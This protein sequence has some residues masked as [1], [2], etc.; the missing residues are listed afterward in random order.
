MFD[1]LSTHPFLKTLVLMN[2]WVGLVFFPEVTLA[3][4]K[5]KSQSTVP[6]TIQDWK[7]DAVNHQLE[8]TL[9]EG[10]SPKYSLLGQ[11]PR[12]VIDLPN[13]PITTDTT[14][15]YTS[16]WIRAI[17]LSQGQGGQG[18]I[19]VDLAS[20]V[21][22]TPQQIRLQQISPGNRWVLIPQFTPPIPSIP[23]P[24]PSPTII[25]TPTPSSPVV[26]QETSP[27]PLPEVTT[28]PYTT[29]P[30]PALPTS[31]P[32]QN[33]PSNVEPIQVSLKVPISPPSTRHRG[34]VPPPPTVSSFS[35]VPPFQNFPSQN[36]PILSYGQPLTSSTI[37]RY[38]LNRITGLPGGVLLPIG[39]KLTL[40]YPLEKTLKLEPQPDWQEILLLKE[41][42]LNSNGQI[43]IPANTPVVGHFETNSKGSRF[44][45]RAFYLNDRFLPF[46]AESDPIPGSPKPSGTSLAVNSTIGGIAVLLLSG[47]SG[48]GLLAGA[49]AGAAT[50]YVVAPRP[51]T[52]QP[53]SI[54]EVRL[55]QDLAP[56]RF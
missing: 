14:Q 30:L 47:F 39:T 25:E 44:V 13:T 43:L 8:F 9:P 36:P 12:I 48:I 24:S 53:G 10:I 50:T 29:Y 52:I 21:T 2:L 49:A 54:V 18:K 42:I 32:I 22:L 37:T 38:N 51:A 1:S 31:P 41:E 11:P 34:T 7:F 33:P 4:L 6:P 20:N 40:V 17:R 26:T 3:N 35:T 45:A 28:T 5:P 16:G 46:T 19:V 15:L 56:W 23:Q 55:T 27:T